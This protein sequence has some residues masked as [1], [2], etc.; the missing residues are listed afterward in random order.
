MLSVGV[1]ALLLGAALG[2][3]FK[4]LVLVPA[5]ALAL[6]T[7]IAVGFAGGNG[8]LAILV[9][10]ALASCSLQIGYLLGAYTRLEPASDQFAKATLRPHI[11]IVR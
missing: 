2:K 3:R 10:A 8:A 11:R 5:L 9:A 4:V 6:L 1:S 7:T